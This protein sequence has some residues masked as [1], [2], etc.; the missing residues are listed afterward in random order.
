MNVNSETSFGALLLEE[1]HALKSVRAPW[2]LSQ[3]RDGAESK[4]SRRQK[5]CCC[6]LIQRGMGLLAAPAP[7]CAISRSSSPPSGK[8]EGVEKTCVHGRV[9]S[10]LALELG[11]SLEY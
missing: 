8:W 4:L 9:F 10:A 1:P 7:E 5:F 6:L 2:E 11:N 3:E